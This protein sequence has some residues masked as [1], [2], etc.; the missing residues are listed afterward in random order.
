MEIITISQEAQNSRQIS[1]ELFTI[2]IAKGKYFPS[3]ATE[4]RQKYDQNFML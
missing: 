4:I 3:N 1:Q 2:K